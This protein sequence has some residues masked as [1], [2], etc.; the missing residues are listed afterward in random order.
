MKLFSGTPLVNRDIFVSVV[1]PTYNR[2]SQL[3]TCLSSLFKQDYAYKY[4]VVVVD[5]NSNDETDKVLGK[6]CKKHPNLK[7]IRNPRNMGS[8]YSRNVAASIARGN[9]VAFTDSDCIVPTDWLNKIH[10]SFQEDET[11][12][13]QGTSER[14][15]KWELPIP[16]EQSL[17]HPVFSIRKGLDAR[18]F[19]IRK[20]L[21]LK[22]RFDTR[23]R[24]AA[25]LDLGHRL[26]EDNVP[27]S[28]NP[29]IWV[30]H[31]DPRGFWEAIKK[32]K[33]RGQA[34]AWLYQKQGWKGVNPKLSYPIWFLS[35]YYLGGFFYFLLKYRSFR[36]SITTAIINLASATY[37][38]SF[39]S[40]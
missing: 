40:R 38:K 27:V 26:A 17:D 33:T 21:F 19:A 4:E 7:V 35:F 22:Y 10:K 24:F 9:V 8:Y 6:Y 25:D 18:N 12:C 23:N 31:I 11:S 1:I 3:N 36:G 30:T 32:G 2:A 20:S 34:Y 29:E 14:K 16:K 13:I 37:F 15:G 5:D 28:F 39:V